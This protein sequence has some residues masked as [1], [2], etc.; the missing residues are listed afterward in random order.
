MPLDR[1]RELGS[2]LRAALTYP[3]IIALAVGPVALLL[4]GRAGARV[5]YAV[6]HELPSAYPRSE[7]GQVGALVLRLQTSA[8][9]EAHTTETRTLQAGTVPVQGWSK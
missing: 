4:H 3:L 9:R 1:G 8:K 2:M 6:S 5:V 7:T